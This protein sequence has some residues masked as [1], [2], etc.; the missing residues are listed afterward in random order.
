MRTSRFADLRDAITPRAFWL[1]VAVLFIQL[2]FLLS[3]VG[4][5][6]HPEPQRIPLAVAAP[7][8]VARQLDGLPGRPVETTRVDD[9]EAA[10]DRVLHREAEAGYVVDPDGDR[11]T[12][13][14][15]SA[16]GQ[17]VTGAVRELAEEYAH[18]EGRRLHTE[19]IAPAS[20]GDH[21]SLTA[22][23]LVVGWLVG[24]YLAASML[25]I[26][27]GARPVDRRRA[28]LRVAAMALYAGL[29]G[30]GSALIVGPVLDALPGHFW[31]IVGIG[32]LTV[33]LTGAVTIAL[34]VLFGVVGIGVAIVLF[35][36][37]GN[38]SAGGAYQRNMIPPFWRAIGDWLPAGAGT[39]AVRNAVYFSGNALTFP[40]TV[41]A[42]WAAAGVLLTVV[43]ARRSRDGD[44]LRL[45]M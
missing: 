36:V 37:L 23:Y 39:N 38:P 44:L 11:D 2:G 3:Y 1:T 15:A 40:L 12:L 34:Q 22:F 28:T 17:S 10:R 41:L 20:S 24:G 32:A 42:V 14:L 29:S 7:E 27:V 13:L 4:A 9:A 31:P 45:P 30:I 8:Q 5:F 21:G 6:H 26:T 25:G 19:D 16:A 18:S 43:C 35:V 33:F